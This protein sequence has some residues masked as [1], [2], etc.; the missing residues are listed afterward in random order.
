MRG[1]DDLRVAPQPDA[2]AAAPPAGGSAPARA[3]PRGRRRRWRYGL[4]VVALLG[5]MAVAMVTAAVQQTPTVDEP[6][7]VGAAAGY[8]DR[9]SLRSNPEH[10]PLGKLVIGSGLAA[11]GTHLDPAAAGD[12]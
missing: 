4:A 6:V 11:A 7:Y 2:C 1:T 12:Q 9:H 8:L 10:P 3:V 5:V